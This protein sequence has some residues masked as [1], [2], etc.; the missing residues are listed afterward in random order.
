MKSL[1]S[2]IQDYLEQ[3][4]KYDPTKFVNGGEIEKLA[5]TKG[6]KA[7]NASRRCREMFNEGILDRR[8]NAKGHVE[9]RHKPN[10]V[11]EF[12]NLIRRLDWKEC[13]TV[14]I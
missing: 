6:Y 3:W 13:G 8:E 11:N 4:Y 10:Q 5:Q 12:N 14:E 2:S 7:S 9:Y 1:E